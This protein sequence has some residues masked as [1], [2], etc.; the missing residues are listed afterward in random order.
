MYRVRQQGGSF[1]GYGLLTEACAAIRGS[2]L[3][4]CQILMLVTNAFRLTAFFSV[5]STKLTQIKGG[6]R[7]VCVV[8]KYRDYTCWGK[9][10][11]CCEWIA[12]AVGGF[13]FFFFGVL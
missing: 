13:D 7:C 10:C 2:I 5:L 1:Y 11:G 8:L 9:C 6:T 4:K 12:G 3:S